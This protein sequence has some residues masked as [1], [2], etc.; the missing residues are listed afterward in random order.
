MAKKTAGRN[1]PRERAAQ[2]GA[3]KSPKKVT[4]ETSHGRKVTAG[5]SCGKHGAATTAPQPRRTGPSPVA[6]QIHDAQRHH[7]AQR[8]G[9]GAT[10]ETGAILAEAIDARA[11]RLAWYAG[12]ATRARDW[13]DGR[14]QRSLRHV[15]I[16]GMSME[17]PRQDLHRYRS[18]FED[19][20]IALWEE[21]FSAVKAGEEHQP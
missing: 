14:T 12:H 17:A 15:S 5:V 13:V 18:L 9:R 6:R 1:E 16:E 4:A 10:G 21:D 7:R 8:G 11:A 2:R 19:P 20:P 3:G